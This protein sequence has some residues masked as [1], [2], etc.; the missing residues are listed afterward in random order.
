[1]PLFDYLVVDLLI[2]VPGRS[3]A[4]KSIYLSLAGGW[5]DAAALAT[6]D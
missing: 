2:G 4:A 6:G 1:L 5:M 3:V